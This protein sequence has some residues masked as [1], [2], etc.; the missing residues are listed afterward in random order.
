VPLTGSVEKE[1]THGLVLQ[2]FLKPRP[3]Q[4][5]LQEECQ[6]VMNKLHN[7]PQKALGVKTPNQVYFGINQS[8][9]LS[10]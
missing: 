6:R 10:G 8:V 3:F 9:A 7:Q 2:Y 1:D 5:L 4:I